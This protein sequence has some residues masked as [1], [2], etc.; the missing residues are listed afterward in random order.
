MDVDVGDRVGNYRLIELV[1]RGGMG[2]VFAGEHVILRRRV[3]IKVLRNDV[4]VDA[5]QMERLFDEARAANRVA[6]PAIVEILDC[7]LSPNAGPYIVMEHL[8]GE[9]LW[10]A[11]RRNR[12]PP[13]LW[14]A[15]VLAQAAEA[16]DAVHAA[17]IVHRDL[18]PGNLFLRPDGHLKILDFGVACLAEEDAA[19]TP[20]R[21]RRI[22]GTPHYMA[23]EQTLAEAMTPAVDVYALGV[24][25]F[26]M[27]TGTHPFSAKSNEAVFDLHRYAPIPSACRRIPSLPRTVDD[28]FKVVLDKRPTHRYETCTSFVEALFEALALPWRDEVWPLAALAWISSQETLPPD[29]VEISDIFDNTPAAHHPWRIRASTS[30]TLSEFPSGLPGE[31][32]TPA[33][34]VASSVLE[35]PREENASLLSV[36]PWLRCPRCED[37][38]LMRRHLGDVEVELCDLCRGVWLE[39]GEL[40]TILADSLDSDASLMALGRARTGATVIETTVACPACS[41]PMRPLIISDLDGGAAASGHDPISKLSSRRP[42]RRPR[43]E[44]RSLVLDRCDRCGGL[45]VDAG[46]LAA[47]QR[48]SS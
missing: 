32:R 44:K 43:T 28:V 47:L 2:Q 12:K 6:H 42:V 48:G 38:F 37:T 33:A 23:P 34:A 1:G 4:P 29:A 19:P 24:I 30:E 20:K 14:L 39:A 15:R 8:E 26:R 41:L 5:R 13:H 16:L 31:A 46:E 18:K 10:R 7:G 3:A 27:L 22:V 40:E 21:P 35:L 36:F 11:L 17:G 9:S 45:W 25:G